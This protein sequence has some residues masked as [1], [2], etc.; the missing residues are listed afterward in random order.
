MTQVHDLE[1]PSV[2]IDLDILERNIA[3]MQTRA[4]DVKMALRPHV[5]THKI[6]EIARMQRDAGAKGICAQKVSEAEVFANAGFEDILISNNILGTKKTTRLTAMARDHRITTVAD[7]PEIIRQVGDAAQAQGVTVRM[8][9]D[10]VT[11]QRRTG[12]PVEQVVDLAKR[13]QAEPNLEFAGLMIYC[14]TAAI[15][16]DLQRALA[17]LDNAGLAVDVISGGGMG[18]TVHADELPELTEL[19]SGAYVFNDVR[20][21]SLGWATLDDCAM[22][23][24]ATVVS[25]PVRERVILDSGSKTLSGDRDERFGHGRIV[26][27]PEARIYKLNEEHA[28][29]DVS[30]C[31]KPP[32]I[33]EQVRIIPWHTC[34][35][36]NMHN[37]LYGVRGEQVEVVWEVAARG[38]VW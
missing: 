32:A 15:R 35:V 19:R 8:L 2:L 20:N 31:P 17:D 36:T 25:T 14:D 26:E 38:M 34:A 16:P 18:V 13:I 23:I 9:V 4:N 7:H 30:A 29:V 3:R 24:T 5:K 28:H 1:T 37:R 10:L 6:P 22:T 21:V 12:A 33:G 11:D 27:Y